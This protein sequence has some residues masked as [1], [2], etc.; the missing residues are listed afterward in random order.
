MLIRRCVTHHQTASTVDFYKDVPSLN[1]E[2]FALDLSPVMATIALGKKTWA[3][4]VYVAYVVL[5]FVIYFLQ[6]FPFKIITGL[7]TVYSLM[8]SY[9]FK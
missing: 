8:K 9:T 2:K 6:S 7:L 1:F 3:L 5:F 4:P